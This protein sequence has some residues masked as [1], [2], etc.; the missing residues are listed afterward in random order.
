[1]EYVKGRI[2]V[3]PR[4]ASMQSEEDRVEAYRDA[5]RVLAVRITIVWNIDIIL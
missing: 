3:D 2:F 1:M 4:M 5:I